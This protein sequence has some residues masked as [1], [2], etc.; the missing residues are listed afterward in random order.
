M[1][2]INVISGGLDVTT[3]VEQLMEIER[4][5]ETLM[6]NQI[7]KNNNK[8]TAF[9]N[10]NT[11]LSTLL[12]KINKLIYKAG[13]SDSLL[14]PSSFEDRLRQ[15][16]FSARK[17]ASSDDSLVSAT[18]TQGTAS[19]T[20][21][22]TVSSLAQARSMAS[23]NFADT[24][25]TTVGTGT[26]VFQTGTN[27]PVTVTIDSSNSTLKGLRNAIN[28]ANAGV[29][30][31]IINDGSA[32]PYRLVIASNDTGTEKAF[33]LADNLSGGTALAMTE[34]Q[35]A[36]DAI[37]TVNSVSITKSSNTISDVIDGVTLNLQANTTSAVSVTVSTDIDSIVSAFTEL[38]TAY[39]DLNTFFSSQ[40][41]YNTATKTAGLLSGDSTVRSVQSK[42]QQ[43]F[44]QS[45]SNGFTTFGVISQIGLS[46]SRDGTAVV[47]ETKLR[48][49]LSSDLEGVAGLVLGTEDAVKGEQ[50]VLVK[51]QTALKGI[52]DPLEGPIHNATDSL[53]RS[54]SNLND[55][56]SKFEDRMMIVEEQLL[57]QYNAADQA[58]RLL[59]VTQASLSS[60]LSSLSSTTK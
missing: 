28:A 3:I 5:P 14:T 6:Q 57:A 11:K 30:A 21:A 9:Q 40:F 39:N 59:T 33:T 16:I 29:T 52:T 26:L 12:N 19:G 37:F 45:V 4:Q 38:A 48:S 18:G 43:L 53:N 13:D 31:T 22:I 8:V 55:Q 10:L 47:N 25:T 20:Y 24:D 46:V 17:A 34:T 54:T 50:S 32:N 23:A 27:D 41:T 51:M 15:S 7:T 44:T 1:S 36:A 56:I 58:L 2:S 49:L 35:A 42:V 60:Q